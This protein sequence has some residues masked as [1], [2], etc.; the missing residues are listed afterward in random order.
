MALN[1]AIKMEGDLTLD[2]IRYKYSI[3]LKEERMGIWLKS[4]GSGKQW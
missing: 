4:L 3:Q 2:G 1:E